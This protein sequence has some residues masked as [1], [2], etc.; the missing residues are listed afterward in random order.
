MKPIF[1]IHAGEYLVAAEIEKSFKDV[2]VWL[3]S[4]DTG[5]DLLLTDKLNKKTVSLQVKFSKDFTVTHIK[6][7]FR[8][9][10]KGSGWWTLDKGKIENS[11]ADYWVFILYSFESKT[12]DYVIITPQDL[13][14]MFG[15]LERESNKIHSYIAVTTTGK[16]YETRGLSDAEMHSICSSDFSDADR[17]L[18][19]Y[20]NNWKPLLEKL[21]TGVQHSI[22]SKQG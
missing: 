13:L 17:D 8:P 19:S 9:T 20:L 16:A 22:C 12:N 5:I 2:T 10:I 14:M 3:P 7:H 15:K 21:R 4:K 6:E 18:T 1:T 11:S